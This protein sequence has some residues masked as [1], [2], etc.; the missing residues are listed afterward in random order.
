MTS[1]SLANSK[2]SSYTVNIFYDLYQHISLVFFFILVD[3][4]RSFLPCKKK[5][6]CVEKIIRI[7]RGMGVFQFLNVLSTGA[8]SDG[9]D[10]KLA[11]L[12]LER[13]VLAKALEDKVLLTTAA[14][15]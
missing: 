8:V 3:F 12:Q 10:P 7:N 14:P 6:R 15:F 11:F 13:T 5:K 9:L 2:F 1:G 4:L